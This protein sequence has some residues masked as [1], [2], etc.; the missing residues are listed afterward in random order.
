[1]RRWRK[2]LLLGGKRIDEQLGSRTSLLKEDLVNLW[3]VFGLNR[4]NRDWVA[5]SCEL[6]YDRWSWAAT[7]RETPWRLKGRPDL[8]VC[9]RGQLAETPR[10]HAE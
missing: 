6:V 8:A 5:I 7:L 1:M 2:P 9:Q 10:D 4:W 3:I